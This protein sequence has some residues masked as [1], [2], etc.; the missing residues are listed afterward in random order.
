MDERWCLIDSLIR[1]EEKTK[2][3]RDKVQL[4]SFQSK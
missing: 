2:K 1:E 4:I 3:I